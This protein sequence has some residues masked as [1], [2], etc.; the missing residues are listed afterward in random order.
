MAGESNP[1]RRPLPDRHGG[2]ACAAFDLV[3]PLAHEATDMR[4]TDNAGSSP[5][6]SGA[7]SPSIGDSLRQGDVDSTIGR[8]IPTTRGTRISTTA[9]RT[10]TTRTTTVGPAPSADDNAAGHAGPSFADVVEAYFDCRR[11]KRNTTSA[12]AFETNLEHNLAELHDELVAGEYTPRPSICFVVTR[13]K[14]REVWAA[15]FRDRIVHHLLYRRIARRFEASFI[16]DSCACIPGRGTLYAARRLEAHVRSATQ[17]WQRASWYLKC[18]VANFFVSIDKRILWDLLAARIHEPWWRE[19]TRLVLS[20]DPRPDALIQ[21][22]RSLLARV[23]AHKSLLNQTADFGLPIGNLSSQFFANVYLDVLDQRVKHRLRVRHYTRYVDDFVLLGDTA[24]ELR[25]VL[26]DVDTFLPARLGLQLNPRKT[27][28]QPIAR[29]I[30]FVGHVIRPWHRS[31]R[32]RTFRDAIARIA[33]MPG[34]EVFESANS[35]FGMLRQASKSHRDRAELANA[36]RRRGHS[37][38]RTLTKAYRPCS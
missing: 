38:D 17:N 4:E 35:Y 8:P 36:V 26:A 25:Q 7:V 5:A 16:A 32:R 19:L 2:Q 30:D 29:G 3:V 20:H 23:P 15:A 27:V 21:S 24:A 31:I 1:Q 10:T 14:P 6:R 33:G 34:D 11:T 18:D 13:P 12:L 28:L 9:T 37:I 22:P